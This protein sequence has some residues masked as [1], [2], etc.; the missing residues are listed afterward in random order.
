MRIQFV[1]PD[2][3]E[4][5]QCF[6]VGE[7]IRVEIRRRSRPAKP[8]SYELIFNAVSVVR[9]QPTPFFIDGLDLVRERMPPA[10]P[11]HDF[12]Q[13]LEVQRFNPD[14]DMYCHSNLQRMGVV[15]LPELEPA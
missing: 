3:P 8:P 13:S 2:H 1:C 15:S 14:L 12:I 10:P 4:I 9:D 6:V 5:C 11:H 7:G